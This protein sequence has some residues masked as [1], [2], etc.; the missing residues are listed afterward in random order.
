MGTDWVRLFN[1]RL[2]DEII[3]FDSTELECF[4]QNHLENLDKDGVFRFG[5]ADD[6]PA[7]ERLRQFSRN[8]KPENGLKVS[9]VLDLCVFGELLY[10]DYWACYA[11]NF[12]GDPPGSIS[13]LALFPHMDPHERIFILLGPG[14]LDRMLASL[15]EHRAEVTVMNDAEISLLRGWRDRCSADADT[16][17]AYFF[18]Y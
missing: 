8:G 14:N 18:D 4:V 2:C 1:K 12:I 6:A 16:M 7:A 13:D 3:S 9:L 10:L 17:V 11:E 15:H 5:F